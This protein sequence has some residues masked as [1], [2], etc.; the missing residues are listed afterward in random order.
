M[1]GGSFGGSWTGTSGL[2]MPMGG[3]TGGVSGGET[4]ACA[5]GSSGT[6]GAACVDLGEKG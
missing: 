4:S 3:V 6:P 1:G 2:A 5:E